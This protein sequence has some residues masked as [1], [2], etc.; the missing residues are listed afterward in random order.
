MA[1]AFAATR[2]PADG[3]VITVSTTSATEKI[4]SR[5]RNVAITAHHWWGVEVKGP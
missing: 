2:P 4:P 5:A 3:K 1:S